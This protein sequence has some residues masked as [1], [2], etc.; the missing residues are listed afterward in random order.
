MSVTEPKVL[1]ASTRERDSA[2]PLFAHAAWRVLVVPAVLFIV[3]GGVDSI[4][5]WIPTSF[6]QAEWEFGTITASLNGLPLPVLGLVLLMAAAMS[7]NSL[8]GVRV[9]SVLLVL[10]AIAVLVMGVFYLLTVPH[11][12]R[13]ASAA[14][15]VTALGLKKAMVKT[16]VQL[17]AYPIGLITS[18]VI[19]W[20]Y[21]KGIE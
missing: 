10:T 16:A 7:A 19:G 13:A 17:V 15:G 6:G 2:R 12:L 9:A 18:A 11:A 5:T 4:L 20:R 14:G 3:V 1:H 21:T 8:P